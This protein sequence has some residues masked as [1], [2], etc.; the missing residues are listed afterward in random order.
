MIYFSAI[1][2]IFCPV[3][4]DSNGEYHPCWVKCPSILSSFFLI[5]LQDFLKQATAMFVTLQATNVGDQGVKL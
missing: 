3:F 5:F 2:N 1:V 4:Q